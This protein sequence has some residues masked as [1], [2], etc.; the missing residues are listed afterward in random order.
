MMSSLI[1][2]FGELG[3]PKAPNPGVLAVRFYGT[4]SPTGVAVLPVARE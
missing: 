3:K 2:S 4:F 1:G